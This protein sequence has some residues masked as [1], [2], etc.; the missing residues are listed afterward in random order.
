MILRYNSRINSIYI[1]QIPFTLKMMHSLVFQFPLINMAKVLCLTTDCLIQFLKLIPFIAVYGDITH[2]SPPKRLSN[3]SKD[4]ELKLT[5]P[6]SEFSPRISL[7]SAS[8]SHRPADR[9][10]SAVSTS[11]GPGGAGCGVRDRPAIQFP[12]WRAGPASSNTPYLPS[13]TWQC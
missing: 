8:I 9:Q 2:V 10:S 12:R 7:Y 6:V 1:C 11:S 5:A 3:N 13:T 4:L